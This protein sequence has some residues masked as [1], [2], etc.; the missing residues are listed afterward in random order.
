MTISEHINE[1]KAKKGL[2]FWWVVFFLSLAFGPFL[3][4]PTIANAA[5][6]DGLVGYW[7]FNGKD[8][9]LK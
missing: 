5:L 7:T 9:M 2:A 1:K 6:T 8:T 4:L 3:L